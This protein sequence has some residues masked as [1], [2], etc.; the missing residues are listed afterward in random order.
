MYFWELYLQ[1]TGRFMFQSQTPSDP[2]CSDLQLSTAFP[3]RISGSRLVLAQEEN[4]LQAKADAE[5]KNPETATTKSVLSV[6]IRDSLKG[7]SCSA[8]SES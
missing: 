4:G 7:V 6:L 3:V 2:L 5:L 1:A 8:G